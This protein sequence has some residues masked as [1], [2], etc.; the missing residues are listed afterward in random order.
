MPLVSDRNFVGPRVGCESRVCG[1]FSPVCIMLQIVEC[2]V[3]HE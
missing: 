2:H 3:L 1:D